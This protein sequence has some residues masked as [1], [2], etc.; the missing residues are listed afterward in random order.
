MLFR[1]IGTAEAP[2]WKAL[3]SATN[4]TL[5]ITA[6]NSDVSNKDTAKFK[7]ILP[8]GN[9]S[10]TMSADCMYRLDD[11]RSLKRDII[12]GNVYQIC[13]GLVAEDTPTGEVPADGW[14]PDE[15]ECWFGEAFLSN[16]TENAP[17]EGQAT[18]NAE[19]TGSGPLLEMEPEKAAKYFAAIEKAHASQAHANA[20]K[21]KAV[22]DTERAAKEAAKKA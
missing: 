3:G 16:Y 9:V 4:H 15:S 18:Y 6:D 2:Q 13:F 1:N 5:A 8:G 21:A 19:F 10:W 11:A 22:L 20:L 14:T 12:Q 17:Y 7:K